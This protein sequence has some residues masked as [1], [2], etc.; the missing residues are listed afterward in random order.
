VA[1]LI[2]ELRRNGATSRDGIAALVRECG[3]SRREAYRVWH[4]RDE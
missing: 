2:A 1:A 3:I 4:A